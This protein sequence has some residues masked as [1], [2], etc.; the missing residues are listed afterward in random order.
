MSNACRQRGSGRHRRTTRAFGLRWADIRRL[1]PEDS[2]QAS[3]STTSATKR[4]SPARYG[5]RVAD[6]RGPLR[7]VQQDRPGTGRWPAGRRKG[8]GVVTRRRRHR[9]VTDDE[10][11]RREY[12]SSPAME[13][14]RRSEQ[15]FSMELGDI[16]RPTRIGTPTSRLAMSTMTKPEI[17]FIA[18]VFIAQGAV[19]TSSNTPWRRAF[20]PIH[21]PP[22]A[23][24]HRDRRGMGGTE[25]PISRMSPHPKRLGGLATSQRSRPSWCWTGSRSKP[26]SVRRARPPSRPPSRR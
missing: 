4:S 21:H 26:R 9:C 6:R 20:S 16:V 23:C 8:D 15:N 3:V 1:V 7:R 19:P 18:Q 22:A 10:G 11:G 12:V 25:V 2:L 14:P 5:D 13:R 24:R 17:V